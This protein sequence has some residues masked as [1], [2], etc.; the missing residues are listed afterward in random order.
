MTSKVHEAKARLAARGAKVDDLTLGGGGARTSY[1]FPLVPG[2]RPSLFAIYDSELDD[3]TKAWS[4]RSDIQG[5]IQTESVTL[6]D[7][8]VN[9]RVKG[10]AEQATNPDAVKYLHLQ[11]SLVLGPNTVLGTVLPDGEFIVDEDWSMIQAVSKR[12]EVS[13]S[14]VPESVVALR[15]ALVASG[16]QPSAGTKLT[17]PGQTRKWALTSPNSG[18][19]TAFAEKVANGLSI[20]S[21]NI[22]ANAAANDR[23]EFTHRDLYTN[24]QRNILRML[25]AFEAGFEAGGEAQAKAEMAK[26]RRLGVLSGTTWGPIWYPGK[27][28]PRPEYTSRMG[29][30]RISFV[31]K[32]GANAEISFRPDPSNSDQS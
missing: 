30:Y 7:A 25:A 1:S 29:L 18:G 31:T 24:Y 26:V 21:A 23:D 22:G 15:D 20:V 16:F 12:I 6:I 13:I 27:T 9:E 5:A 14:A 11:A 32:F 3:D 8:E 4:A 2:D 17:K 10:G 19:D 28:E